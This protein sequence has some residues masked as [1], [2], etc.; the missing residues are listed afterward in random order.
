MGWSPSQI[1][2][3]YLKDE[4]TLP[5]RALRT[6]LTASGAAY[7]TIPELQPGFSR[8]NESTGFMP[9]VRLTF[10]QRP[11]C[12]KVPLDSPRSSSLMPAP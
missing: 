3:S 6:G 8:L 11:T 10:G 7:L 12:Y 1:W 2:R 4:P 5:Q 9:I